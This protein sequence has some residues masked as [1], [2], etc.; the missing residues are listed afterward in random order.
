HRHP[1]PPAPRRP[2]RPRAPPRPRPPPPLLTAPRARARARPRARPR[3]SA[4]RAPLQNAK[5]AS[6]PLSSSSKVSSAARGRTSL[7]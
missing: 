2:P 4:Q 5:R 6:A 1:P 3:A 7:R